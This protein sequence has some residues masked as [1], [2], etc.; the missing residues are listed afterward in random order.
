MPNSISRAP[1]LSLMA[2]PDLPRIAYSVEEAA[3]TIGVGRT[4]LYSYIKS[5]VLPVAKLG[6][7]TLVRHDDLNALLGDDLSARVTNDCA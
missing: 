1:D 2:R 3:A 7:R 5:G 6:K 4:T